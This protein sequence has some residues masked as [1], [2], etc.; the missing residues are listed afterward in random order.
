MAAVASPGTAESPV[1]AKARLLQPAGSIRRARFLRPVS[2]Q[3]LL[4]CEAEQ[5]FPAAGSAELFAAFPEGPWGSVSALSFR[6]S[7]PGLAVV[8]DHRGPESVAAV[9]GACWAL[10]GGVRGK[11]GGKPIAVWEG[12]GV[13]CGVCASAP[14]IPAKTM[15]ARTAGLTKL[16]DIK[17]NIRRRAP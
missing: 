16:R 11:R 1:R 9:I 5:W 7:G 8:L 12:R 6:E 3:A 4:L 14:F 10:R 15:H 13:D 17:L 2:A